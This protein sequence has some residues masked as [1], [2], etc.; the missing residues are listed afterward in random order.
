M[1]A[2][3]SRGAASKQT[4]GSAPAE[5]DDLLGRY[6]QVRGSTDALTAPLSPEDQTVQTMPDVSPTKW[7]RAHTSWFFETFVLGPHLAG[8]SRFHPAYAYLFNS[9]YEAAGPRYTRARRGCVSRPGCAEISDYRAHVDEAMARLIASGPAP[10]ATWLTELGLHHE[11]Q[12]QELLLMDIKHVL[13]SSPLDPA[14]APAVRPAAPAAPAAD[15]VTR[16]E[17]G[18][19]GWIAHDGGVV[20]VGHQGPGFAFDNEGPAHQ[21]LLQPFTVA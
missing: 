11:Q 1:T 18:P 10:E 15:G 8:Y 7:H 12:H 20:E 5:P 17:H 9:Y 19:P 2:V 16:A 4:A 21:V 14:Y 13:S 3:A 6:R